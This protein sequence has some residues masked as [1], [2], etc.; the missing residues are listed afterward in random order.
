MTYEIRSL[1]VGLEVFGRSPSLRAP[2][3][4]GVSSFKE[5]Q[6]K[7]KLIEWHK[8]T[9]KFFWRL[10]APDSILSPKISIDG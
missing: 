3:V 2:A 8:N 4:H 10:A 7:E 1:R 5:S 6:K 9:V